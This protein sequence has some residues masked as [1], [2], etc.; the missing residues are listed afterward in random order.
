MSFSQRPGVPGRVLALS[1][2]A[3]SPRGC[4]GSHEACLVH[5]TPA[6]SA[7]KEIL[8]P[9]ISRTTS[10]QP[11][12]HG[13]SLAH[14][15]LTA[16]LLPALGASDPSGPRRCP[17]SPRP[18]PGTTPQPPRPGVGAPSEPAEPRGQLHGQK[19]L[20]AGRGSSLY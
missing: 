16:R 17:A 11:R 14:L 10:L 12:P 18:A 15:G 2:K 4:A 19:Q 20:R 3:G 9:S 13:A 5:A 7:G 6:H 1:V 8:H